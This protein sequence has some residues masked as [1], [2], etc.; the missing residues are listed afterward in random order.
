MRIF[1]GCRSELRDGLCGRALEVRREVRIETVFDRVEHILARR[2]GEVHSG[3]NALERRV[4]LCI[5]GRNDFLTAVDTGILSVVVEVFAHRNL[6]LIQAVCEFRI[7]ERVGAIKLDVDVELVRL[8]VCVEIGRAHI[9]G[10]YDGMRIGEYGVVNVAHRVAVDRVRRLNFDIRLRGLVVDFLSEERREREHTVL[11]DLSLPSNL[12]V[13]QSLHDAG[14]VGLEKGLPREDH[15]A[16]ERLIRY[17]RS[18]TV[19][20]REAGVCRVVDGRFERLLK[21]DGRTEGLLEAVERNGFVDLRKR[22]A[23]L[24]LFLTLC[25]EFVERV[26]KHVKLLRKRK[27]LVNIENFHNALLPP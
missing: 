19:R 17:G 11:N 13:G 15:F 6:D 1:V 14:V 25:V 3:E 8:L 7:R 9:V 21:A 12:E 16:V 23:L 10:L 18:E 26:M 22:V 2:R 27:C 24:E 4:E 5:F 20:A